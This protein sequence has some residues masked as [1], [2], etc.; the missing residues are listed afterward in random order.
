[1]HRA[2]TTAE[3][4]RFA[5]EIAICATIAETAWAAAELSTELTDSFEAVGAIA[6]AAFF[7]RPPESQSIKA[8]TESSG[9]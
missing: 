1:M 6:T 9:G 8:Q 7:V 2:A 4:S 3:V 5:T